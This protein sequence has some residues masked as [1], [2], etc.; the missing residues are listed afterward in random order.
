M[1]SPVKIEPPYH[2]EFD[3]VHPCRKAET[4]HC[5]AIYDG[6]CGERP[7]ARFESEDEGPWLP[8]CEW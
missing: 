5:P 1:D 3:P 8:E 7:C 6:V 4:R 2:G